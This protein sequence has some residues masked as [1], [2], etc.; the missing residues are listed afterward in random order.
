VE[1]TQAVSFMNAHKL[2]QRRT[3]EPPRRVHAGM[4]SGGLRHSAS[5]SSDLCVSQQR[6]S[7]VQTFQRSSTARQHRGIG[8]QQFGAC[9]AGANGSGSRGGSASGTSTAQPDSQPQ[10]TRPLQQTTLEQ[11]TS[12]MPAPTPLWSTFCGVSGGCWQ[13]TS[14]AFSPTTGTHV[15]AM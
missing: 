6:R 12:V 4:A 15:D 11:L 8:R 14:A 3:I 7:G 10:V 2:L 1:T 9:R 13:G 5:S